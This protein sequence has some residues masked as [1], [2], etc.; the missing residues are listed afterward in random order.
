MERE[1]QQQTTAVTILQKRNG[2]G[3]V[4]E[5]GFI[6]WVHRA[7]VTDLPQGQQFTPLCSTLY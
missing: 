4:Q 6:S 3:E 1:T 7:A 2:G 5:G